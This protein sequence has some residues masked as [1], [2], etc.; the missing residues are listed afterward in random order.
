MAYLIT[1]ECLACGTCMETCPSL[2][3]QEGNLF[4]INPQVCDNCGTCINSCPV[5]AIIEE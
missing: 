2:A 5:G 4:R 1:D 3:I